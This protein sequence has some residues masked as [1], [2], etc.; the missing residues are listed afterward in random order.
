MKAQNSED[1]KYQQTVK[2]GDT[3]LCRMISGS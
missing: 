3:A 2:F 1:G